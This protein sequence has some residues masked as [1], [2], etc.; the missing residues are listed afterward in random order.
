MTQFPDNQGGFTFGENADKDPTLVP[1]GIYRLE[2]MNAEA[3]ETQKGDNMWGI[4]YHIIEPVQFAS[5]VSNCRIFDNIV[6]SKASEY[7]TYKKLFALG[8]NPQAGQPFNAE[9]SACMGRKVVAVV[10]HKPHYKDANRM[11][12][13][14]TSMKADTGP[15]APQDLS[16]AQRESMAGGTAAP[17]AQSASTP[18]Q[19]SAPAQPTAQAAPA[20]QP[21]F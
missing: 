12:C 15:L 1:I 10:G 9:A 14:V 20:E 16:D 7:F 6:F 3:R 4:E 18:S 17:A 11:V 5:V 2:V 13:E 8:L 19:G 21:P